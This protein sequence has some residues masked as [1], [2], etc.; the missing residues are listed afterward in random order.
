MSRRFGPSGPYK[1]RVKARSETP[2]RPWSIRQRESQTPVVVPANC[3]ATRYGHFRI[4]IQSQK[5]QLGLRFAAAKL[6][7]LRTGRVVGN[8]EEPSGAL[9]ARGAVAAPGLS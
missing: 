4:R 7:R 3:F 2:E 1:E 6:P 8:L 5:M 9:V